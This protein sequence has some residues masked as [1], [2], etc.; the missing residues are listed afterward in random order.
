MNRQQRRAA[1]KRKPPRPPD[2]YK[3][4]A[5][6]VRLAEDTFLLITMTVLHDKFGFG[7]ERLTR[8]YNQYLSIGDS[9]T[10]GFVSVYDLNEQLAKETDVWVIDREQYKQP[11]KIRDKGGDGK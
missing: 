5:G 4:D 8:F 9:L 1:K 10:R 3:P 2:K 6:T 7:T 11:W